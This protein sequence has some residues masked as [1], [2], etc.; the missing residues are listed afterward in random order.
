LPYPA[1]DRRGPAPQFRAADAGEGSL[2]RL[3]VAQ[4]RRHGAARIPE[5]AAPASSR[6]AACAG[7]ALACP[8]ATAAGL[9]ALSDG[10][11]DWLGYSLRSPTTRFALLTAI[12]RLFP[13]QELLEQFFAFLE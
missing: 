11:E 6:R 7:A 12:T 5:W 13:F 1:H 3:P 10:A 9:R 2:A 4:A 8:P